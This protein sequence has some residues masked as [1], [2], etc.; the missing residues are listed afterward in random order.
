MTTSRAQKVQFIMD[1]FTPFTYFKAD[2]AESSAMP[3]CLKEDGAATDQAQAS[4]R[5]KSPYTET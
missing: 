5:R 1:A 2:E 4:E 3:D